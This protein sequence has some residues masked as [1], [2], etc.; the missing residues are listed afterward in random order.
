MKELYFFGGPPA[1][2]DLTLLDNQ[3]KPSSRP[4]PVVAQLGTTNHI[5]SLSLLSSR[6]WVTSWGFM[7]GERVKLARDFAIHGGNKEVDGRMGRQK[8][9]LVEVERKDVPL[10]RSCL[11]AN[12]RSRLSFISRSLM[13]RCNSC[14]ASSMRA[15]SDE[16]TTKMRPWVPAVFHGLSILIPQPLR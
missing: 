16:S 1:G 5:L 9:D 7:A 12:T 14:F 8:K 10:S 13:M 15:A 4:S 6:R 11:L 3:A 2:G